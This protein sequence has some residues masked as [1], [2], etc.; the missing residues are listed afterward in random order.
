[1]ILGFKGDL[2]YNVAMSSERQHKTR[3]KRKQKRRIR[4]SK[5][6]R[7]FLL[8]LGMA[9]VAMGGGLSL[10]G[11]WRHQSKFVTM[12]LIYLLLFASILF[13]RGAMVAHDAIRR[14]RYA[15]E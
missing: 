10:F 1:L 8:S 13:L 14:T 12:G 3:H 7:F 11:L 5:R 2:I 9:G 4:S 6:V 15:S